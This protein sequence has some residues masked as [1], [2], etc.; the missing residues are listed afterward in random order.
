MKGTTNIVDLVR[1]TMGTK[2]ERGAG[3]DDGCREVEKGGQLF[4][5]FLRGIVRRMKV[6]E[7]LSRGAFID[8]VVIGHSANRWSH[9]ARTT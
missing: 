9:V 1:H 5:L 6:I 3:D 2:T 4:Y 8:N 7:R